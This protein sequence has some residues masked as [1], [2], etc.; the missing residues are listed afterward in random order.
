[1]ELDGHSRT[2]WPTLKGVAGESKE[3]FGCQFLVNHSLIQAK[4]KF[5]S[6]SGIDLELL[7]FAQSPIIKVNLEELI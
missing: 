3:P 6:K 5:Q 2:R 7:D 1:M 4:A